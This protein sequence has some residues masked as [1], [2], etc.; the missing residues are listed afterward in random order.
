MSRPV[1]GVS[2]SSK[3]AFLP[4]RV[5]RARSVRVRA[6]DAAQAAVS[7]FKKVAPL[8]WELDTETPKD[9]FAFAGSAPERANGRAAMLGFTGLAL[10]EV[11]SHTP[12]LEQVANSIPAIILV[13]LTFTV[14]TILPKLVSGSS[15][16][17]LHAAASSENLKAEGLLGQA[18]A[19]FDQSLELWSGRLAMIG[20]T[21]LCIVEAFKGDSLF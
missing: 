19:L 2:V 20:I 17:D 9:V 18:L 3:S 11:S 7:P 8:V 15:L 1:Q 14:A 5:T 12:A 21:G 10:T 16:K 6:E 4:I 13:S